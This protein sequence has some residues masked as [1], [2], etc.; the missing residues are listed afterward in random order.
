MVFFDE[1][2]E[3]FEDKKRNDICAH[4]RSLGIDAQIAERGRAE[5]KI[6]GKGSLGIIDIREGPIRWVN[7]GRIG[8]DVDP[9]SGQLYYTDYGVPDPRLGKNIPH[10]RIK[11]LKPL[12]IHS[13]SKRSLLFLGKAIDLQWEGRDYGLGIVGCLNS[14]ISIKQPIMESGDV[15]IH[16]YRIH[17]CWIITVETRDGPS[18]KL[19]SC[20]QAIADHLLAE[21]SPASYLPTP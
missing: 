10:R 6:G 2:I 13:V 4:L 14:D 11:P 12:E 7:V 17:R 8:G 1:V 16:T 5:E 3:A 9:V 21:W 19:W 15:T 18:R 20:Y